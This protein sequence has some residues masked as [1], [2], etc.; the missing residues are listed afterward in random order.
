MEK[1]PG[2]IL[3]TDSIKDDLDHKL[4]IYPIAKKRLD[5]IDDYEIG[6]ISLQELNSLW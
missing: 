2:R 5:L 1:L 4:I 3:L 6:K